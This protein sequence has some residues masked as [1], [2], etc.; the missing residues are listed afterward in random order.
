MKTQPSVKHDGLEAVKM[1]RYQTTA[2]RYATICLSSTS[3][4]SI[5]VEFV[6]ETQQARIIRSCEKLS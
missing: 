2:V 3:V 4:N 1:P 5:K 6:V